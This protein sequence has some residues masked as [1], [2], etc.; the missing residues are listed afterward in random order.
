MAFSFFFVGNSP[1]WM[2]QGWIFSFNPRINARSRPTDLQKRMTI[3]CYTRFSLPHALRSI[4]YFFQIPGVGARVRIRRPPWEEEELLQPPRRILIPP[5]A[6]A[7][8]TTTGAAAATAAAVTE[9]IS[10][11]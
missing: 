11:G 5:P 4:L 6:A 10:T 2:I 8:T 9:E 1:N 7:A 3:S